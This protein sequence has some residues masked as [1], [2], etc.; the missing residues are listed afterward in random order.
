MRMHRSAL[1]FAS[2]ALSLSVVA[3]ASAAPAEPLAATSADVLEAEGAVVLPRR[4][5]VAIGKTN[6]S[7]LNAEK[8]VTAGTLGK[9]IVSL[10]AA[11]Q[12]LL[13]ADRIARRQMTAVPADPEAETTPG[14]DSVMAVLALEQQAVS[15]L[16]GLFSG[17][18]GPVVTALRSTIAVTQQTRG[19]LLQKVIGLDPEGAGADYADGMADTLDGY[20][21]EVA[22]LTG[23]LAG[24]TLSTEGAT[25]LN[26]ALARSQAALATVTAAYGGGE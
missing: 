3:S 19:R 12:N 21:V 22:D 16:A 14:P 4:L 9:A 1:A 17:H 23:A 24:G 18:S 8:R 20:T 25:A 13:Q 15:R 7:L 26:K 2:L 10:R 11:R 5:A 6:T